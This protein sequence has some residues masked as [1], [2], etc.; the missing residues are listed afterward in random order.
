MSATLRAMFDEALQLR[1][2]DKLEASVRLLE[3]IARGFG[4]EHDDRLLAAHSCAQIA[5]VHKRWGDRRSQEEW[6]R[7]GLEIAPRFELASL[8]LFNAL[9]ATGRRSEA[10]EEFVRFVG[11]KD[12]P[13]YQELFA[14]GFDSGLTEEE[15]ALAPRGRA[16]LVW[17]A[18]KN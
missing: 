5:G 10:L 13:G 1:D 4:S 17:H 15:A 11:E 9:W 14:S 18:S 8:G 12:S 3:Q 16:A 2:N 7:R 6:C